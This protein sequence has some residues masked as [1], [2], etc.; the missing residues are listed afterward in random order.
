MKDGWYFSSEV[1]ESVNWGK[2][3]QVLRETQNKWGAVRV[4]KW[5]GPQGHK[6]TFKHLNLE[7]IFQ[8]HPKGDGKPLKS[9]QR[10]LFR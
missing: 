8:S 10:S 6:G 1:R 4:E 9:Y 5:A 2:S 7:K 3:R